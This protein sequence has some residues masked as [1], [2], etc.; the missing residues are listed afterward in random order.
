MSY[1]TV[2]VPVGSTPL[3]GQSFLV[4]ATGT[5]SQHSVALTGVQ[6][7]KMYYVQGTTCRWFR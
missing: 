7:A 6:P 5:G 1:T 2:P 3:A 4:N